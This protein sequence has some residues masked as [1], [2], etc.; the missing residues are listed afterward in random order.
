MRIV[1]RFSIFAM[2]WNAAPQRCVLVLQLYLLNI[3]C[4]VWAGTDVLSSEP[5]I[6]AASFLQDLFLRYGESDRLTLQQLKSLLN[7]LDV[8]VGH[9]N[10]SHT[11][12]QQRNLSWVKYRLSFTCFSPAFLSKWGQMGSRRN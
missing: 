3:A 6:T 10:V 1:C 2:F 8:G 11:E 12:Q 7:H 5:S 9:S 4:C